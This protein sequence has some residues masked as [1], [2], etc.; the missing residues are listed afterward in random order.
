MTLLSNE[1]AKIAAQ[2]DESRN[3]L[4]KWIRRHP[5]TMFLSAIGAVVLAFWIGTKV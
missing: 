1:A 2:Y 4:I 5:W 3:V